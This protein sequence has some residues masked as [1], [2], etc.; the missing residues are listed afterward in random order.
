MKHQ[1]LGIFF[2]SPV[3]ICSPDAGER[4]ITQGDVEE[5]M[6][7]DKRGCA[8]TRRSCALHFHSGDQMK[9]EIRHDQYQIG[10]TG[11]GCDF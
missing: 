8:F 1:R 9:G 4:L 11:N 10:G 5:L 3:C 6:L 7:P 2:I